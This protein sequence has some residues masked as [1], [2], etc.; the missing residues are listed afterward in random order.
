MLSLLRCCCWSLKKKKRKEKIFSDKP[1]IQSLFT[2][3]TIAQI[4]I[5]LNGA[6]HRKRGKNYRFLYDVGEPAHISRTCSDADKPSLANLSRRPSDTDRPL[7]IPILHQSEIDKKNVSNLL[8][9]I[10]SHSLL[11]TLPSSPSRS[12][13][14]RWRKP[15]SEGGRGEE[16]RNVFAFLGYLP[17]FEAHIRA[18]TRTDQTDRWERQQ[19]KSIEKVRG[20]SNFDRPAAGLSQAAG[21]AE[22]ATFD[23]RFKL[24]L[25]G[26]I[27]GNSCLRQHC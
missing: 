27:C 12:D 4:E 24:I 23:F 19:K 18:S 17:P 1:P 22:L 11:A 26:K 3:R 13:S 7:V 25:S 16:N 2:Y 10:A 20:K 8:T 5:L 14:D 15:K 21:G 9:P 6:T